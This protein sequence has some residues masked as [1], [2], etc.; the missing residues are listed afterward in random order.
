MTSEQYVR[1]ER[2]SYVCQACLLKRPG[3][4]CQTPSWPRCPPYHALRFC[5]AASHG[6]GL[7]QFRGSRVSGNVAP[8]RLLPGVVV[9]YFVT[10]SRAAALLDS[11]SRCSSSA[12]PCARHAPSGCLHSGIRHDE[13]HERSIQVVRRAQ[14]PVGVGPANGPLIRMTGRST[15]LEGHGYGPCASRHRRC[16]SGQLG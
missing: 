5:L 1:A 12:A 9:T 15:I 13:R 14:V 16:W 8:C 10:G 2:C 11:G 3:R 7:P 6:V 4:P